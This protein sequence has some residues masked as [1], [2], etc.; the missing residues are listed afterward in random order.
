MNKLSFKVI[1][2]VSFLALIAAVASIVLREPVLAQSNCAYPPVS[3]NSQRVAWSQNAAVQ[4]NIDP[5]FSSEQRAGI[6]QAFNN[7]QSANGT[8]GNQS[9][10]TFTFTY[11]STA[12]SGTDTFQ[13]NY[14]NPPTVDPNQSGRGAT[15]LSSGA[16]SLSSATTYLSPNVTLRQAVT[17]VMVHEIGH[18]FGLDDC[19]DC[20]LQDSVMGLAP[21]GSD[22]NRTGRAVSPTNCDNGAVTRAGGYPQPTPTPTPTPTP[23][24][25]SVYDEEACYN[26]GT[27]WN[28]DPEFCVCYYTR[29]EIGGGCDATPENCSDSPIVIDIAGNGFSL[30]DLANGVF[31]DL[32]S[33][34][35]PERLSWTSENSDDAWL[36]LDRNG[37]GLI[38]NGRE[39]FGNRTAQPQ[40]ANPNGFIALGV[41]DDVARGGNGDGKISDKDVIFSLLRL[42]RDVNHNG[43]SEPNEL[44]TL[45]EIGSTEIDLDYKKSKKTDQYGNQFRYRSKVKDASGAQLGRWAWDVFLEH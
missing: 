9:G 7:W 34:A 24:S 22:P 30:T 1:A 35:Q 43:I 5:S 3:A 16:N 31:F 21:V 18:A 33:D 45:P 44:Y 6:V 26:K 19:P 23:E 14:Q 38:D 27:N 40:S 29:T 28:W 15:A 13:V 25:C 42:W 36:V 37:N 10:V 11:N 17:E 39:M 8:T 20:F 12:V 4:V 32:N 2:L 41:Y